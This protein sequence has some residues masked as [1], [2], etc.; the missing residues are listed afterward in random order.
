M[1]RIILVLGFLVICGRA[2]ATPDM[3]MSTEYSGSQQIKSS[4]GVVYSVN[5]NY[6]GVVAGDVIQLQDSIGPSS[7]Y[8]RF[9]CTASATAGTCVSP[10]SIPAYYF[11][12]G[13]YYNET[14]GHPGTFKTDIQ[15]F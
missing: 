4:S 10:V 12:T 15:S 3:A 9:T 6:V 2:W 14:P 11:G 5:V 13:I 1:K 7:L 8:T